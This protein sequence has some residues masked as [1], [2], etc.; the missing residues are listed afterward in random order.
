M[1]D[2]R[3]GNYPGRIKK[4]EEKTGGPSNQAAGLPPGKREGEGQ[5]E[6][7]GE[8]GRRAPG[9]EEALRREHSSESISARLTQKLGGSAAG[10]GSCASRRHVGPSAVLCSV[11]SWGQLMGRVT[12]SQPGGGPSVC[13][14]PLT[15]P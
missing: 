14:A 8:E 4:R 13:S 10:Q 6:E 12:S 3:W 9:E 15:C 5:G 11:T 2:I 7:R 1:Q